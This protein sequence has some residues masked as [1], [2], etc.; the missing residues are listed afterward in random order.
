MFVFKDS[1]AF[2]QASLDSL[3]NNLE[4]EQLVNTRKW[5]ESNMRRH[6]GDDDSNW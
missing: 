6:G 2:T 1:L 4:P 5:L 3:V